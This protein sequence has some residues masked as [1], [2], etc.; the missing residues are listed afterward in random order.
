MEREVIIKRTIR[1]IEQLPTKRIHEV[2]DF[3]E[4]ISRRTN[5]ALITE[6][7]QQM[8]SSGHTF[9]FLN[10]EPALYSVNDLKEWFS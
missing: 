2:N 1:G 3:V 4:F 8:S 9:D 7:L 6:G 10:D 5:D